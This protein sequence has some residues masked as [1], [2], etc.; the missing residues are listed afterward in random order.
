MSEKRINQALEILKESGYKYTKR[1]EEILSFLEKENKYIAP[2]EVY[3]FLSAKY[4]GISYDT[5]YRN[6]SD[7]SELNILE[8]TE[9]DGE[10]KYR[11][12]CGHGHVHHH[13]F[14]C[15]YCG[16]TQALEMCP[17]TFFEEQLKDVEIEGHRFEIFGKCAN[18]MKKEKI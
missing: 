12:H 6:L 3:D 16:A 15:T 14:I 10:K 8:E 2:K 11:F 9:F 17:M 4:A 7:F 1:R 18:C 5:I 13:H